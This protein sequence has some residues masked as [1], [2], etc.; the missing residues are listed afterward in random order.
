MLFTKQQATS[1]A[2]TASATVRKRASA[3][4]PLLLTAVPGRPL[5]HGQCSVIVALG[6]YTWVSVERTV[7]C[8]AT[9]ATLILRST[10]YGKCAHVALQSSASDARCFKGHCRDAAGPTV[11]AAGRKRVLD[12]STSNSS[13]NSATTTTAT[14]AAAA[15]S[16]ATST[17]TLYSG[18]NTQPPV[19]SVQTAQHNT[20]SITTTASV[21][22]VTVGPQNGSSYKGHSLLT[23]GWTGAP[24][25]MSWQWPV[26]CHS[27][28]CCSSS[29]T[30]TTRCS[31]S[32]TAAVALAGWS[33][34]CIDV[35]PVHTAAD[36]TS[37]KATTAAATG[38]EV[39]GFN[40]GRLDPHTTRKWY[41]K[42]VATVGVTALAQLP[43]GAFDLHR[44]L[45]NDQEE[46]LLIAAGGADGSITLWNYSEDKRGLNAQYGDPPISRL[47]LPLTVTPSA[48]VELLC[49]HNFSNSSSSNSSQQAQ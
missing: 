38:A 45:D 15:A 16:A 47:Q 31:S 20:S 21:S 35:I 4:A 34:G 14:T 6:Q 18:S 32:S 7:V 19:L 2:T 30:C 36:S 13:N 8:S 22:T 40:G 26:A 43:R 48:V 49:S 9:A 25:V 1:T 23:D 42:T 11:P 24:R 17:M 12:F 27:S 3:A 37:A 10:A 28:S 29:C 5:A 41:P 39:R 33:D 44:L 46:G